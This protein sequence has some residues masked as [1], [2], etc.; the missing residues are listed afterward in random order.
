MS[1]Y[2][3]DR[4]KAVQLGEELGLKVTFDSETPGIMDTKTG[5]VKDLM[6]CFMTDFFEE[7]N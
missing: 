7:D 2:K 1:D 4:D 6:S 5:E 3:I